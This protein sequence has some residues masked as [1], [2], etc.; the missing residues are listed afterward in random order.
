MTYIA[1]APKSNAATVA[2]GAARKD[3]REGRTLPVPKH[4][5]DSHYAGSEQFGH[6][7]NYQYSHDHEGGWVDQDYLPEERRYY[8]PT[9][10]GY[11]AEIGRRLEEWRQR[12]GEAAGPPP[13]ES[14]KEPPA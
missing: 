2:I 12:R 7:E 11:E 6:G 5:R 1:C 8:E 3:V 4:L 13:Q 14:G 10:R 9:D